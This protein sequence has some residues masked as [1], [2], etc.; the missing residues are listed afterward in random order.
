[1]IY[2]SHFQRCCYGFSTHCWAFPKRIVANI[3]QLHDLCTWCVHTCPRTQPRTVNDLVVIRKYQHEFFCQGVQPSKLS[4]SSIQKI[5]MIDLAMHGA[6]WCCCL[7]PPIDG[8]ITNA[9]QIA[10]EEIR[11][12]RPVLKDDMIVNSTNCDCSVV[13]M[14]PA[15]SMR[16]HGAGYLFACI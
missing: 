14:L 8:H 6:G 16:W 11:V 10:P 15:M 12:L 5:R 1:M 9:F 3:R 7:Q 2:E 13:S 4:L